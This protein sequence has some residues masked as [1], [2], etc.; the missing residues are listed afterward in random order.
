LTSQEIDKIFHNIE[1]LAK[2]SEK[3][4]AD[5][6]EL[7]NEHLLNAYIGATL[8]HYAPM[9]RAYQP[10][11]DNYDS[12][13]SALHATVKSNDAFRSFLDLSHKCESMS[14]ESFLIMPIQRLPRYLLLLV[15]LLKNTETGDS[16]LDDIRE[17]HDKIK[18]ITTS[19]NDSLHLK[20]GQQKVFKIQQQ[21]EKDARYMELVTPTRY[22][23]KEGM[24]RKK[25]SKLSRHLS[26]YQEYYFFLF[27]D[28]LVYAS[29]SGIAKTTYHLRHVLPLLEMTVKPLPGSKNLHRHLEIRPK[30]GKSFI[31]SA[32][33]KEDRDAWFEALNKQIESTNVESKNLKVARFDGAKVKKSAKLVSLTGV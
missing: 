31:V 8:L 15:E 29:K 30:N 24:M 22:P 21:F 20:E 4:V 11:L 27:N 18:Q 7:Q 2:L 13:L 1:E 17:A 6:S 26:G 32:D 5:L 3:L 10:Y 16:A 19:I 28:I 33:S 12:A 23:V 9:F 25:Y 14:L